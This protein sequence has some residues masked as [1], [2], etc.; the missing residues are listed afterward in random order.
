MP[1]LAVRGACGSAGFLACGVVGNAVLFCSDAETL[2]LGDE[3]ELADGTG[4]ATAAGFIGCELSF[5]SDW[6]GLVFSFAA[7]ALA[8]GFVGVAWFGDVGDV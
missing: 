4:E 6:D 7:K 8:S 3:F 5:A 1:L 2:L